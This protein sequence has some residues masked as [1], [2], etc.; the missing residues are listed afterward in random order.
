MLLQKNLSRKIARFLVSK[1][2]PA[3]GVKLITGKYQS[4]NTILGMVSGKI[5]SATPKNDCIF[6]GCVYSCRLLKSKEAKK[7]TPPSHV[8]THPVTT[9]KAHICIN[10]AQS[11][12]NKTNNYIYVQIGYVSSCHFV[13]LQKAMESQ[14]G[15]V[16]SCH[17]VSL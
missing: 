12:F 7:E 15:Y 2:S 10:G 16:S 6:Q 8:C 13:S 11:D 9:K 5:T 1:I 4:K 3:T 14:I 17:F